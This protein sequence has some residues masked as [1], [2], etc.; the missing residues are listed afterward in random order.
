MA[1]YLAE[2]PIGEQFKF[3]T[4][5]VDAVFPDL[6]TLI[7]VLLPNVYVLAGLILLILLI[8]GGLTFILNAGK[9]PE[10]MAKGSQALTAAL[11]G[12]VI[13]FIAYW[14]INI[15]NY[16]IPIGEQVFK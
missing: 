10:E 11:I 1:T 4:K 3:G 15:V 7:N 5:G 8:F 6:A 16:L 2:V 12:F 9:K 14:I 13:I